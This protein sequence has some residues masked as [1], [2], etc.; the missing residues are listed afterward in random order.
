MQKDWGAKIGQNWK[1]K[2]SKLGPEMR[3]YTIFVV[4]SEISGQRSQK[5]DSL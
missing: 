4:T 1:Q 3:E 5:Y 2:C